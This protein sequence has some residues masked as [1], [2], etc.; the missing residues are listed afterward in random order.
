MSETLVPNLW[1]PG[2]CIV[3]LGHAME[4]NG[5]LNPNLVTYL[6]RAPMLSKGERPLQYEFILGVIPH[7]HARN[8]AVERFLKLDSRFEWLLMFDNDVAPGGSRNFMEIFDDLEGPESC[9]K[10]ASMPTPF[11]QGQND[12]VLLLNC[13]TSNPNG[14]FEAAVRAQAKWE[15]ADMVGA[16]GLVVH[17]SVL[18]KI[19][20]PWFEF[21]INKDCD[22]YKTGEDFMFSGKVKKAGFRIGFSGKYML[23]H[24]HAVDLLTIIQTLS[25]QGFT[26][27]KKGLV[28]IQTFE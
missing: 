6:L 10:V 1:K 13:F 12:D 5:W 28:K 17:R 18:E 22:G 25:A 26:L 2:V 11:F 15:D 3:T 4:R 9:Y 19:P 20:A 14:N 21:E 27:D 7:S 24:F 16:A 8:Q 23:N